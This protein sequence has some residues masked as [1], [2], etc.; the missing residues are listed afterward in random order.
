M[1]I[2]GHIGE[3]GYT[4]PISIQ[5]DDISVGYLKNCFL[6]EYIQHKLKYDN[7]VIKPDR[8]VV[9]TSDHVPLND[10]AMVISRVSNM[11]DIF[12]SKTTNIHDSHINQSQKRGD[13][14]YYYAHPQKS[15]HLLP[16][17]GHLLPTGGHLL[18][19]GG[20]LLPTGGPPVIGASPGDSSATCVHPSNV[21][22]TLDTHKTTDATSNVRRHIEGGCTGLKRFTPL[23]SYSWEDI[24]TFVK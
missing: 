23:K 1:R 20:H 22:T 3:D 11:D 18:P 17:G 7:I 14:S 4:L 16:T 5:S 2:Y 10:K 9:W 15:I 19:T 24:T 13:L 8:Y 21:V 6:K 12:L